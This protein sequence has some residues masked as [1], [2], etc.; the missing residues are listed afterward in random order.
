M[1]QNLPTKPHYEILNGL[2][3]IAAIMDVAFYTTSEECMLHCVR[4]AKLC[5]RADAQLKKNL[6]IVKFERDKKS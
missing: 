6:K 2:L 5:F 3:G 1:N 4:A